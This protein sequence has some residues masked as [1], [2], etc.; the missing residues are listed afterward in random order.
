M[1]YWRGNVNNSSLIP[2]GFSGLLSIGLGAAGLGVCT[3]CGSGLGNWVRLLLGIAIT[4]AGAAG[5]DG[6]G[7]SWWR[8]SNCCIKICFF[9]SHFHPQKKTFAALKSKDTP[10]FWVNDS[11]YLTWK[12][13][14]WFQP[15]WKI[16]YSQI[17]S[18]CPSF[19]VKVKNLW[20][21]HLISVY[22][23]PTFNPC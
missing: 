23:I 10:C 18:S 9:L 1:A 21:H 16:W 22:Y 13:G 17:G 5:S 19:R 3:G 12:T 20:N 7:D 15:I 2:Q 4:T 8:L 11:V 6:T 14:W